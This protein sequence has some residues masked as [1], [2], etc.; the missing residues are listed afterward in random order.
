[1]PEVNGMGGLHVVKLLVRYGVPVFRQKPHTNSKQKTENEEL[2]AF[3][4]QTDLLTRK[5][6]I[7]ALVPL[8]RLQK[9]DIHFAEILEQFRTFVV[10]EHGKSEAMPGKH[11]DSVI[12]AAIACYNL[13]AATEFKLQRMRGADLMRMARDPRYLAPDGFRRKVA[14]R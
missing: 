10:T 2:E 5:W 14:I 9:V 11:D 13:G 4:W 8:I 3:G 6:I 1:M 7:D 12:A